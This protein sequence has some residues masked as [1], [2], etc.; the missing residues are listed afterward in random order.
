MNNTR[1][2]MLITNCRVQSILWLQSV[3]SSI[4]IIQSLSEKASIFLFSPSLQSSLWHE[5]KNKNNLTS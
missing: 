3:A 5:D 2:G 1:T 4:W